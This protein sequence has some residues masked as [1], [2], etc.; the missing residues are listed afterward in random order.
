MFAFPSSSS[1]D[2]FTSA[3]PLL[4]ARPLSAVSSRRSNNRAA[5]ALASSSSPAPPCPSPTSESDS[6]D[7]DES[8]PLRPPRCSLRCRFLGGVCQTASALAYHASTTPQATLTVYHD[9]TQQ[10]KQ[11]TYTVHDQCPLN[12]LSLV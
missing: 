11:S 4:C 3:G 10:H 7:D 1:S 9:E 12:N 8:S 2:S 5:A 6:E